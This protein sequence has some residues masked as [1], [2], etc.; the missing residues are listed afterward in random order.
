MLLYLPT[1][2]QSHLDFCGVPITGNFGDFIAKM[3]EMGYVKVAESK[4][5][6]RLKGKF[7]DAD[8]NLIVLSTSVSDTVYKVAVFF[9]ED[10]TWIAMKNRYCRYKDMLTQ[11]YG[12]P[13]LCYEEFYNGY[14][15]GDG[16]EIDALID[17][18]FTYATFYQL[19][20][21]TVYV[22][23]RQNGSVWIC[24]EDKLGIQLYDKEKNIN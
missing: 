8:V 23:I 7:V 24:Y 13:S 4:G 18:A 10:G 3:N 12:E 11:K 17:N 6:A 16:Y 22:N 19:P 5:Y 20:K 21:G 2:A 15:D 9:E 14:S 1:F